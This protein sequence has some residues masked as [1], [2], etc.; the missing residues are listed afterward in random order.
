MKAKLYFLAVPMCACL[1]LTF[2]LAACSGDKGTNPGTSSNSGG[3]PLIVLSSGSVSDSME[4]S[5]FGVDLNEELKQIDISGTITARG[6]GTTIGMLKFTTQVNSWISFNGS[7]VPSDGKITSGLAKSI[8]LGSKDTYIDLTNN[9]ID[10][11]KAYPIA[12]RACIDATEKSC[13]DSQRNYPATFTKPAKYCRSSSSAVVSSSSA[14]IEWKFGDM[15]TQ[16]IAGEASQITI[17]GAIKFNL[18]V[19]N[20]GLDVNVTMAS[21]SYII[22]LHSPTWLEDSTPTGYL[23]PGKGY[24]NSLFIDRDPQKSVL[25]ITAED[26]YLV[27]SGSTRYLIRFEPIEGAW[28]EFPL[29]VLYWPVTQ[30]PDL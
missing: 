16:N 22:E 7:Q 13:T 24:N 3:G 27:L 30:S 29:K 12:V 23:V 8:N 10:C 6:T 2:I 11:D 4:I 9:D 28:P 15:K 1:I 18:S 25:D 5:K 26:Y 20:N 17:S 14:G 19:F 21:G